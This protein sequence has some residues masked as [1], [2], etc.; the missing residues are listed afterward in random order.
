M[1]A[2]RKRELIGCQQ[3]SQ[4]QKEGFI[5]LRGLLS[6]EELS[7]LRAAMADALSTLSISPNSYNVTAAA[8]AFWRDDP[9]N[10]NQGSTQHDLA[11]L[12]CAVR[13]SGLP[14]L[15]DRAADGPRGRFLLDTGVWR[16]VP[17]LAHFAT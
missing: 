3:I 10:D 7:V 8:D 2:K 9:A 11:A 1:L 4:F 12:A 14:R 17:R 5:R 15:V 13:G 6:V 16:R